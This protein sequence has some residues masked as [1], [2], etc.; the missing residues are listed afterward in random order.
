MKKIL[1]INPITSKEFNTMS[2]EYLNSIKDND[3][4]I[5]SINIKNGP[6]SIEA[7]YDEGYAIPE[8]L[9]IVDE[10]S[11][12]VNAIIINCFADPAI[13][14]SREITSIPIIGPAESCLYMALMLGHKYAVIS[15][16]KNIGPWIEIQAREYGIQNRLVAAVGIE[17]PVL[18][19]QDNLEETS[20][21]ILKE[22]NSLIHE[23][24]A[25][26]IILGCTG[27]ATV[28]NMVQK[29]LSV[30][31]I[32]PMATTLKLAQLMCE[33]D[34]THSKIGLYME[35]NKLKITGY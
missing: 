31:L 14:A 10:Y 27:M 11:T 28:A 13:N 30:P 2:H 1:C 23:K 8:V 7:F 6:A 29:E 17:L 16:G 24:G 32:E 4:E 15:T 12:K 22:A 26:V 20:N 25:E 19:L 33:L 5:I 21:Y 18:R 3:S 9:R 34:L 35:P